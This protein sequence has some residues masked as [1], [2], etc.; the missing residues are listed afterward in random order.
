MSPIIDRLRRISDMIQKGHPTLAE[1][2]LGQLIIAADAGVLR[3]WEAAI[4]RSI[5]EFFVPRQRMSLTAILASRLPVL[6]PVPVNPIEA[7]HDPPTA[8][9][10]SR[11]RPRSE[12]KRQDVI[13]TFCAT[14]R[15]DAVVHFTRLENLAGICAD[16]LLPRSALEGGTRRA[17]FNDNSRIDGRRDAVCLSISFPNYK[18]FYKYRQA[19]LKA[20]W[21]VL[22]IRADVLWEL[23]CAFCWANAA[24]SAISRL[25]LAVLKDSSSLTKM[26]ADQCEVSGISRAA[27]DIPDC[28]PTNPQA[29]VL[30]FSGVSLSYVTAAYFEDQSGRSKFLPPQGSSL[31]I[32][33]QPEYY[34]YR[35]DWEAWKQVA[36]AN[37][38]E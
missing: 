17:V 16:G 10:E 34:R 7:P 2:M 28:Y 21:A 11:G 3:E 18:M 13:R 32:G 5:T 27:C 19:D 35:R 31:A 26:F 9:T 15:I 23:D 22:L 4:R 38:G 1:E 36:E 33:V 29:E 14:R 37:S 6:E 25:P 20:T 30:A 8:F 24:C 12:P